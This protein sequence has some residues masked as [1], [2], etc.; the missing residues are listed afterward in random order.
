MAYQLVAKVT[1]EWIGE[2]TGPMTV[3]S[4]QSL[5]V[6]PV[7]QPVAGAVGSTALTSA[8]LTTACTALGTAI[9][10]QLE[11]AANLALMQGWASGNP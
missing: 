5:F 4:A 1:M 11:T 7:T 8:Q 10:A 2:G 3:P 6:G 9:A